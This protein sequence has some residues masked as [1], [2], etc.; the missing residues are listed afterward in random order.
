MMK[1]RILTV[2]CL[3]LALA[4]IARSQS[5]DEAAIKAVITQ[6]FTG[7]EKGD[8]AMVHA[9][10]TPEVTM[11]TVYRD[12]ADA[13]ALRRESTLDDF[14]KAVGTPHPHVWYEEVWNLKVQLDGDF[15]QAWCDYA[16]YSG[17]TFSHCG[18]DA[19]QLFRD[20][21]GAWKIFHLAD[22]RRK[23]GCN[24]PKETERK[25]VRGHLDLGIKKSYDL[26]STPAESLPLPGTFGYKR[27]NIKS[28]GS[29]GR[30]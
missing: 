22:T 7:M 2:T 1:L 13:P 10:F 11:A 3:V 25:H 28:I 26:N 6:L 20:R 8:S 5:S 29:K 17:D 4:G 16:F 23:T 14:L 18:V 30:C 19:F 21:Y 27:W 15:A 24:I 12:K 9:A